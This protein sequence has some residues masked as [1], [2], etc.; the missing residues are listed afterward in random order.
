MMP[1]I[2]KKL[3]ITLILRVLILFMP[4]ITPIMPPSLTARSMARDELARQAGFA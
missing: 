3:H 1:A 4:A 2:M